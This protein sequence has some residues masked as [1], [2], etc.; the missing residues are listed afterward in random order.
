[1]TFK[2]VAL[3]GAA[4][5]LSAPGFASTHFGGFEDTVNRTDSDYNDI[6]FSLAG[7]DSLF[8]RRTER[9]TTSLSS[10]RTAIRSGIRLR[11][12]VLRTTWAT[13]SMGEALATIASPSIPA[14]ITWRKRAI[15]ARAFVKS[16]QHSLAEWLWTDGQLQLQS[17]GELRHRC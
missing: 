3:I 4:L 6:V 14:Q 5:L 1:M 2:S 13:A 11:S 17:F 9:G 8:T 10:E 16:E 12:T 15:Q 7:M